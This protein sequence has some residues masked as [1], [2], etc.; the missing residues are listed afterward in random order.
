MVGLRALERLARAEAVR[1]ADGECDSG[2]LARFD[3]HRC[4]A[5]HRG[6][7]GRHR[8]RI[9]YFQ[10]SF[11]MRLVLYDI[12]RMYDCSKIFRYPRVFQRGN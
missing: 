4:V 10:K 3:I 11:R 2:S 9:Q 12:V 5:E 7:R 1:D 6:L 8:E